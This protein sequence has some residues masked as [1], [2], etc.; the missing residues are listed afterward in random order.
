MHVHRDGAAIC[1]ADVVKPQ[2]Q[3]LRLERRVQ[4]SAVIVIL[5]AE[6]EARVAGE[7]VNSEGHEGRGA[8]GSRQ[9]VADGEV[10]AGLRESSNGDVPDAR[11]SRKE[12]E[13]W[14]GTGRKWREDEPQM[15]C[16]K[17]RVSI[18]SINLIASDRTSSL[19]WPVWPFHA[20]MYTGACMH[21][22]RRPVLTDANRQP[23]APVTSSEDW[24]YE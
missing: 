4:E 22:D 11:L 12:E 20:D 1:S 16:L 24:T 9:G 7:I 5:A 8:N 15:I 10:G 18:G 21:C 23:E 17:E 3:A 14:R 2:Y 13:G 19:S 6:H